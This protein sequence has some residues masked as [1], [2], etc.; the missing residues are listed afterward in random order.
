MRNELPLNVGG[1]C[2]FESIVAKIFEAAGYSVNQS[3]KLQHRSGD[4]DIVAEKDNKRYCV[5]VKYLQLYERA[6]ERIYLTGKTFGMTPAVVVE[7]KIDERKRS[8]YL[9]KYPD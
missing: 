5:E 9:E 4:I 7:S 3:V 8:Y 1:E 2:V 6:V